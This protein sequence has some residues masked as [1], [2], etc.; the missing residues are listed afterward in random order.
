MRDLLYGQP[1]ETASR[2]QET[3]SLLILSVKLPSFYRRA[4]DER[5]PLGEICFSLKASTSSGQKIPICI[6]LLAGDQTDRCDTYRLCIQHSKLLS[7]YTD[8][9]KPFTVFLTIGF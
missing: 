7:G 1:S 4:W 3:V 6:G 9:L 8:T 5:K 2:H